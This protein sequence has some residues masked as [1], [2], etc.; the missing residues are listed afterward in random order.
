M[1]DV[2]LCENA[3][4]IFVTDR[5]TTEVIGDV[6]L[7]V[8][9]NEFVVIFGPGQCG[10]SVLIN[11]LSG[12]EPPTSGQVFVYDKLVTEPG[13]DRGIVYQSISLFPWLTVMGNVELGPKNA[14][15]R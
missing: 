5:G 4:K 12:L 1:K 2:I 13:P 14:R 3:S 7:S 11:L 6:S 8:K 9:E 15:D 10:K